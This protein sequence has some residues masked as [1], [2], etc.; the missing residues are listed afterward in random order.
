MCRSGVLGRCWVARPFPRKLYQRVKELFEEA[1]TRD[2][3]ARDAYLAQ[4]CDGDAELRRE[5]EELLQHD[6][7]RSGDALDRAVERTTTGEANLPGMPERIGNYRILRVCGVGG[8]G[9]VYEAENNETNRRVALK[10]IQY[11]TAQLEV[12]R[13]FRRETEILGR[14]RHP[15]IAQIHD[16][17]THDDGG[18]GVPY[19][20]MEYVA[21]AAPLTDFAMR[22]RLD[23]KERLRLFAQ[24]CDA[25]G[26][27]HHACRTVNREPAA[28]VVSQRV[29]NRVGRGVCIG[30]RGRD[31]NR[32]TVGRVLVDR[33][34]RRVRVAER[35]DGDRLRHVRGDR[36]LHGAVRQRT[37]SR[38]RSGMR[39]CLTWTWR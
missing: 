29:R 11:A 14:L 9:T 31:P 38:N 7:A 36:L 18:D 37:G 12:L 3:A 4:A 2:A 27:G 34:G 6:E 8:M 13:R 26:H 10:V 24:A 23:T 32:R 30:G 15:N 28:R 5:V 20:A 19:F 25:V 16:A 17:G 33:V 35:R 1:S 39:I 21:N 22:R